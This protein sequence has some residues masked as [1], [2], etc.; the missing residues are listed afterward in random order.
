MFDWLFILLIIIAI[1]FIVYFLYYPLNTNID[2]NT[3]NINIARDKKKDLQDDLEKDLIS[4]SLYEKTQ[5]EIV[6]TLS[7][8]LNKKDI[9]FVKINPFRWSVLLTIIFIFLS[10]SIYIGIKLEQNY[11][12]FDSNSLILEK[13]IKELELHISE[14]PN[15]INSLKILGLNYFNLGETEKSINIF[16][17]ALQLTTDDVNLFLQYAGILA[18]KNNNN[19]KGEAEIYIKKALQLNPN[20]IDALYLAGFAAID[21]ENYIL[22]NNYW[23]KALSLIPKDSQKRFIIEGAIKELEIQYSDENY[24]LNIDISFAKEILDERDKNDYLIVYAKE[25]N[26]DSNIPIAIKKIPI[27]EFNGNIILSDINSLS[28]KLSKIDSFIIVVRI[29]SSGMA[30]KQEE[31]FEFYS[32]IF[33]TK[34]TKFIDLKIQ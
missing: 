1:L 4:E 22:A 30:L 2:D 18:Y 34:E 8:E 14:N 21:N 28:T 16:K 3:S 15:D 5:E 7:T 17:K 13:N 10:T 31:D 25:V 27:S 24:F 19:F 12:D 11:S 9:S 33:N 29:S 20:L 32:D 23:Q 6:Q 26:S